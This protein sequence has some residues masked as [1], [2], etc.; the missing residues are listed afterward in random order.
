MGHS[1]AL[2]W[3]ERLTHTSGRQRSSPRP[4]SAAQLA[5]HLSS[6][7][8]HAL[9]ATAGVQECTVPSGEVCRQPGSWVGLPRWH[10][11]FVVLFVCFF[12]GSLGKDLGGPYAGENISFA[13]WRQGLGLTLNSEVYLLNKLNGGWGC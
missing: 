7:S 11:D 13:Q 1:W 6:R 12:L 9:T 10:W 3:A 2:T 4:H 5:L 8:P